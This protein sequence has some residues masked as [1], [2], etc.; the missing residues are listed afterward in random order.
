MFE[1]ESGSG[2]TSSDSII[3]ITSPSGASSIVTSAST[4]TTTNEDKLKAEISQLLKE[5]KVLEGRLRGYRTMGDLLVDFRRENDELKAKVKALTESQQAMLGEADPK[6]S[7]SSP[8]SLVSMQ[9]AQQSPSAGATSQ[10]DVGQATPPSLDPKGPPPVSHPPVVSG[11]LSSLQETVGP[12]GDSAQETKLVMLPSAAEAS[13]KPQPPPPSSAPE[14]GGSTPEQE[15]LEPRTGHHQAESLVSETSSPELLQLDSDKYDEATYEKVGLQLGMGPGQLSSSMYAAGGGGGGGGG[16]SRGQDFP[17]LSSS[18]SNGGMAQPHSHGS[19]SNPPYMAMMHQSLAGLSLNKSSSD[20]ATE[21]ESIRERLHSEPGDSN[22]AIALQMH[23]IAERISKKEQ[24]EHDQKKLIET[25][26]HENQELKKHAKAGERS[27]QG[28]IVALR[29]QNRRLMQQLQGQ[30]GSES[31]SAVRSSGSPGDWVHVEKPPPLGEDQSLV[32]RVR[33]LEH[34]KAELLRANTNWKNQWDQ[35]EQSHQ[36]KISELHSKLMMAEQEMSSL[37]VRLAEQMSMSEFEGRMLEMKR[38]ISEEEN[39]KEEAQHQQRLAERRCS[40]LQDEL[41]KVRTQLSDMAREK[42][43]LSAELSILKAHAN[44]QETQ[45]NRAT[46]A[47]NAASCIALEAEIAM[48]K[49]QLK[50]FAEDF[51]QERMD[52]TSAQAA[53]DSAKKAVEN[54][55]RQSHSLSSQVKRLEKQIKDRDDTIAWTLRQNETFQHEASD[56]KRKLAAEW[57]EKQSLQRRL[58]SLEQQ[59]QQQKPPRNPYLPSGASPMFQPPSPQRSSAPYFSSQ[60]ASAR[61]NMGPELLPGAWT[62][63]M[64]NSVNYPGRTVCERCG[65]VNSPPRS[66][67]EQF[68]FGSSDIYGSEH[69]HLMSRGGDQNQGGMLPGNGDLVVD[70]GPWTPTPN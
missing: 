28:E 70:S 51:E 31:S 13:P 18:V 65:Y 69:A 25:L 59:L 32:D 21:V 67:P 43:A 38:R 22:T 55:S 33:A 8:F 62:C 61:T 35:M 40:E 5:N 7:A 23:Q 53:R 64:C 66:H 19:A 30:G 44:A 52:R 10:P 15:S 47:T 4:T 60:A 24:K 50:V 45:T 11:P 36:M 26:M 54:L 14:D 37:K 56:F 16:G 3:N 1:V 63:S 57:E 9:A 49:E 27:L 39:L 34:Q 42:Q 2:S 17:S 41:S 58:L 48:L 20:L 46:E 6:S 29:E 68:G 12:P